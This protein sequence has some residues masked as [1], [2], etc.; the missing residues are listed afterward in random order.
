MGC[1]QNSDTTITKFLPIL[2]LI[3]LINLS[4]SSSQS[5]S[6]PQNIQTFYPFSPPPPPILPPNPPTD[7]TPTAANPPPPPRRSSSRAAVGRAIGATA[8]TTIVLSGLL[9][10]L[11]LRR[12]RRKRSP[13]EVVVTDPI[14]AFTTRFNGNIKGLI[15]DENG[16]DVLYWRNMEEGGEN[17]TKKYYNGE[18]EEEEEQEKRIVSGRERKYSNNKPPKQ[19]V[20]LLRGKSST[21]QS[22]MWDQVMTKQANNISF[23]A[24]EKQGSI[25]LTKPETAVEK[26]PPP[27]PPPPPPMPPQT[28]A[29]PPLPPALPNKIPMAP[30][31]KRSSS[32]GH[33]NEQVKLKPLH[34]DK[35][36]PN[37]VDHSMVWD[38]IDK[39]SFKFDGDLME[40]LFGY[41]ATNRKSPQRDDRSSPS[42][43]SPAKSGP[44]PQIFIL[45]NRKSQNTSIVLKSLGVTRKEIIDALINGRGLNPDTIEKLAKIAPSDEEASQITAFSGDPT[46]L[47]DAE[48]FLYHLLKSVPSAFA[49]FN[50]MLFRSNHE[51]EI[52]SV[53]ESLKSIELA[54]NELRSR[55]LFLKLLEAVLKAGNRLNA[56]TSRGNA[57]AFNLTALRKLSD[58]KSSDGKTTLLEFVVQEVVRAEGKRCVLNKSRGGSSK[59]SSQ[60]SD[61]SGSQSPEQSKDDRER[62]YM[63]LGLPVI[64]GLSAEFSNVKRAAALDYDFLAKSMAALSEKVNSVREL[65]SRCGDGGGFVREMKGFLDTAELEVKVMREEEIRVMEVVRKTTDYYQAGGLEEKGGDGKLQ[66]FVIV[67]DF[68]GM[69]DRVCVEIARNVQRRKLPASYAAGE[70]SSPGSPRVFRFP[71]L[72]AN[73]MSDNSKSSSDNDSEVK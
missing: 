22:P 46:R 70:S 15:V 69:V 24:I 72:P 27:P 44:P 25:Q 65:V 1:A 59:T 63:M 47:A 66:L 61:F 45:D 36:N 52:N 43:S 64:G 32:T 53:K 56:G 13:E 30:P 5:P 14:N 60:R 21:S 17:F 4:K 71:K 37:A 16:L 68:L 55:G 26:T 58:V 33:K 2:L 8:A 6:S 19:E 48:S 34:W 9:F 41:V 23:N 54:C 11:L 67:R 35:V 73:F 42:P 28:A 12:S 62:E 29:P 57:Q 7:R 50:A 38:K 31:N 39:G 18:A 20:P 10:F 49:R 3:F 51:S 40:A